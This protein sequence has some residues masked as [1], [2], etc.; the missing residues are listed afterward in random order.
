MNPIRRR[1]MGGNPY[2]MLGASFAG[3]SSQFLSVAD[4]ADL[5]MGAGVRMTIALW[6]FPQLN[7]TTQDLA[8]KGAATTAA[9]EYM[10]RQDTANKIAFL[11]SDGATAASAQST[12]A[13]TLNA[14]NFVVGQ[15]DGTN[16]RSSVNNGALANAAF[17]TD[18]QDST[19][20]FRLGLRGD[21]LEPYTGTLDVVGIWRRALTTTEISQ[22]YN[23]GVGMAY[24][25]LSGSLLTNLVAWFDLD[26]QGGS[27]ATW[28][29]RAGGNN[30][31]AGT[32]AAAPTS[33]PG[34]R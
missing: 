7:A 18:I 17:S 27:G 25:D 23:G 2:P 1:Q 21:G 19:Q 6:A 10:V 13:M 16:V 8:V 31:T 3:G 28:V 4:N 33:A 15:Y 11:V 30:L 22:L 29:D 9:R 5:S 20:P 24:R 26:D 34:K 32:G 12:A 14:W